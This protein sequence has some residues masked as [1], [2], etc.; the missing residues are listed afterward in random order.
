MTGM[1]SIWDTGKLKI[2]AKRDDKNFIEWTDI[3]F[4]GNDIGDHADN[5]GFW[6][7]SI[8]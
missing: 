8:F 1:T 3:S 2:G 7:S 6:K 4:S 5:G